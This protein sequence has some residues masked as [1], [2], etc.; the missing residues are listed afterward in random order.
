MAVALVERR[1]TVVALRTIAPTRIDMM[2]GGAALTSD[3]R[4]FAFVAPS[5]DRYYESL[6]V[7]GPRYV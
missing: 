4:S 6:S 1:P 2:V 3:N 7:H 5:I